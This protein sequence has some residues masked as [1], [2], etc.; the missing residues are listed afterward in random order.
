MKKLNEY[1]HLNEILWIAR[2]NYPAGSSLE[3]HSHEYYQIYY[4]ISG[5]GDFIT[6]NGNRTISEGMYLFNKPFDIHGITVSRDVDGKPLRM[7]EVK[8]VVFD[9][10]LNSDLSTVPAVTKDSENVVEILRQIYTEGINKSVYYYQI[11]NHLLSVLLY[12][13]IRGENKSSLE[14]QSNTQSRVVA[15]IKEYIDKNLSNDISLD[16][17]S[18]AVGYSKN[19]L[20]KTFKIKTG[21]TINSYLNKERINKAAAILINTDM[22]LSEISEAVGYNNIYHFNK[23]FKK[24]IGLPPGNFRRNELNGDAIASEN[25]SSIAVIFKEGIQ[26]KEL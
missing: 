21:L 14:D 8:F 19:Y 25:V 1:N 7:L 24:M 2:S 5:E 10:T 3:P 9:A 18:K 23:T 4:V 15:E 17:L 11:A 16:Q 22:E 12:N 6:S 26:P 20:C 13:I